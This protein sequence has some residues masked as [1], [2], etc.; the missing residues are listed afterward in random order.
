MAVI[1]SAP[2][3]RV[4]VTHVAFPEAGTAC[5][6]QPAMSTPPTW[7]STVPV[8]VPEA[9][10]VAVTLAVSVTFAPVLDGFADELSATAVAPR[11]TVSVRTADVE[12]LKLLSPL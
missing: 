9:G 6:L 8:R 3:V 4:F 12:P 1:V 2:T 7:N 5:A 10:A 11:F